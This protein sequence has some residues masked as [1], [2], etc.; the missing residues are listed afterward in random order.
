[1]KKLW[2]AQLPLI[3]DQALQGWENGMVFTGEICAALALWYAELA[4]EEAGVGQGRRRLLEQAQTLPVLPTVTEGW[5][6]PENRRFVF[7]ELPQPEPIYRSGEN[8]FVYDHP[9][10]PEAIEPA[11]PVVYI[12]PDAYDMEE[13]APQIH[14]WHRVLGVRTGKD[15][16]K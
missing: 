13:F 15:D 8:T 9:T 14:E 7:A 6:A 3:Y 5:Q 12:R 11:R 16:F 1:M 2:P 4:R 10:P